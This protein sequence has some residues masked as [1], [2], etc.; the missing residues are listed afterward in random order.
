[1]IDLLNIKMLIPYADEIKGDHVFCCDSSARWVSG[2]LIFTIRYK[3]DENN[4]IENLIE[5]I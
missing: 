1:M 5:I 2:E 3:F 4:D